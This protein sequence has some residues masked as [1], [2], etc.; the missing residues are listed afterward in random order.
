MQCLRSPF[1]PSH[2][3]MPSLRIADR[4]E[5]VHCVGTG[6]LAW[7]QD[8]VAGAVATHERRTRQPQSEWGHAAG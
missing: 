7:G 5:S 4:A 2:E 1:Q 3:C 6:R 8:S